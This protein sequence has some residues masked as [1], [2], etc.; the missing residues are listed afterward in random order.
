MALLKFKE[1][2][3]IGAKVYWAGKS[4]EVNP[5]T[6]KQLLPFTTTA[7]SGAINKQI[8]ELETILEGKRALLEDMLAQEAEI[9]AAES[10]GEPDGEPDED[11]PFTP[12]PATVIPPIGG[13]GTTHQ[14]YLGGS[15]GNQADTQPE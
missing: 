2:V 5:E 15:N 14:T 11:K 6:A 4:Y 8:A 12:T 13:S 7:D 10:E 3:Q 1:T 9:A